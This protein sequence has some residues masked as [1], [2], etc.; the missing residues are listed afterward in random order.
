MLQRR[1]QFTRPSY[2]INLRWSSRLIYSSLLLDPLLDPFTRPRVTIF[3]RLVELSKRLRILDNRFLSLLILKH[4]HVVVVLRVSIQMGVMQTD[5]MWSEVTK[6]IQAIT[7]LGF[8]T[9]LSEHAE[10]RNNNRITKITRPQ[11]ADARSRMWSSN[12]QDMNQLYSTAQSVARHW[13][14][15]S[16]LVEYTGRVADRKR[17]N[18]TRLHSLLPD[19]GWGRVSWSSNCKTKKQVMRT[20]KR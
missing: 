13:V 1:L 9:V 16:I 15:S 11:Q 4:Y 20:I 18:C 10:N 12:R 8:L 14:W 6:S 19:T 2:S 5:E 17:D 3:T 7:V